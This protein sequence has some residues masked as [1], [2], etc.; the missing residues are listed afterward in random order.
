YSFALFLEQHRTSEILVEELAKRGVSVDYG[1]ELLDTKVVEA[2]E[3]GQEPYVETIIRR[4]LSGDNTCADEKV[5]IGRVDQMQEQEGKAYETQ[6]V[7][8]QYLIAAD[9]GRSTVRH[10]L[11]IP[12]PGRLIPQKS[13]MWDGTFESD[14]DLSGVSFISGANHKTMLVFPLTNGDVR[15]VVEDLDSDEKEDV[16]TT[17]KDLTTEKFEKMASAAIAPSTFKIKTTS[18]LTCFKVNERRADK[19]IYKNRIFLIGDAAHIHSPAGGQ[20][21]NTGLHDAHNLAW[22]LALVLNKVAPESLLAS[23]EGE[24]QA[25][26]DRSIALSAKLLR[27][28]RANGYVGQII[29]RLY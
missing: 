16:A 7:R 23:Y 8:S 4:A 3:D 20:G 9:G 1:W 11:N 19:F 27:V 25:M 22:K 24:R 26:A 2:E 5:F 12:F 14:C 15:V 10:K 29:K 21:L 18:W 17:L 6:T 13:F 28:N